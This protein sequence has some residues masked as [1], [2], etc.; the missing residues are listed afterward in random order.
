MHEIGRNAHLWKVSEN[1]KRD[2]GIEKGRSNKKW[3][4]RKG[5][6]RDTHTEEMER[7]K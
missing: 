5:R 1:Q 4:I 3:K 2:R 6:E 7:A